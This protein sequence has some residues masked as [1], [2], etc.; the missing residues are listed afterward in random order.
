MLQT[1]ENDVFGAV[2][3][4][5]PHA[6]P[7]DRA[8]AVKNELWDKKYVKWRSYCLWQWLLWL[9]IVAAVVVIVVASAQPHWLT[10]SD[11]NPTRVQIGR[12]TAEGRVSPAWDACDEVGSRSRQDDCPYS[13]GRR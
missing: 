2:R 5:A 8:K 10:G 3:G 13:C 9:F 12:P 1:L 4:V 6:H 11:S 7:E